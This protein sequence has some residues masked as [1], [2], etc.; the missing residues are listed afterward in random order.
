[1]RHDRG[2]DNSQA[3]QQLAVIRKNGRARDKAVHNRRQVRVCPANLNCE[4]NTDNQN[5]GHH[6]Q[7]NSADAKAQEEQDNQD[8]GH[9]Q[10]GPDHQ[11]QPE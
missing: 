9:G 5:G 8:V 1:M 3:D 4:N 10:E 2:P 7:F 6:D 11:R